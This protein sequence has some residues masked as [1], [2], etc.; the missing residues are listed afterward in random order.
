M[1]SDALSNTVQVGLRGASSAGTLTTEQQQPI[2]LQST[3][4]LTNAATDRPQVLQCHLQ[5]D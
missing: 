1:T 5:V 4:G 3:A 2:G